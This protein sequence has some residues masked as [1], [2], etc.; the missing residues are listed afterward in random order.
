MVAVT[1]SAETQLAALSAAA[2]KAINCSQMNEPAKVILHFFYLFYNED[3]PF[4][5]F[6]VF[7]INSFLIQVLI[8][9]S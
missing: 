4:S 5:G 6:G 3:V 2:R 7:L 8:V 9:Q 1:I